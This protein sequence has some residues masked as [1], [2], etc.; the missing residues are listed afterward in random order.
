M[1]RPNSTI[2]D[3]AMTT[4]RSSI[5]TSNNRSEA[6][7]A[8]D[9][10]QDGN[11]A[12][13]AVSRIGQD[14]YTTA[15]SP[16]LDRLLE[17]LAAG[18]FGGPSGARNGPAGRRSKRMRIDGEAGQE[19][20]ARVVTEHLHALFPVRPV[21]KRLVDG[22]NKLHAEDL[23]HCRYDAAD[24]LTELD[25]AHQFAI[26]PPRLHDAQRERTRR[27]QLK[28]PGHGV[29]LDG[30]LQRGTVD[31]VA[32]TVRIVH[33]QEA[34]VVRTVEVE[35][36]NLKPPLQS[37]ED[38]LRPVQQSGAV[39]GEPATLQFVVPQQRSGE[40]PQ[41]SRLLHEILPKKGFDSADPLS[42]LIVNSAFLHPCRCSR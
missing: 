2:N 10:A 19:V 21:Q 35:M 25:V 18:G 3:M 37:I 13:G 6:F 22:H 16:A 42:D 38:G 40:A 34:D 23:L 36:R 39:S 31:R 1:N 20:P 32:V 29:P 5:I 12:H 9:V 7:S 41:Q 17:R 14:D 11:S 30:P 28:A 33:A 24:F 15:I 27:P 8:P 4:L 26:D